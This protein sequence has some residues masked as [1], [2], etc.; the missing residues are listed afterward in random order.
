MI[1][2]NVDDIDG[3]GFESRPPKVRKRWR[4]PQPPRMQ[5]SDYFRNWIRRLRLSRQSARHR[6]IDPRQLPRKKW[7]RN[8]WN[9]DADEWFEAAMML[10]F[11]ETP[12]P[13]IPV[14]YLGELLF[15]PTV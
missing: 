9:L 2:L 6:D 12:P 4:F 14:D 13:L 8:L 7:F 10:P 3:I 11:L 1:A 5:G 15:D